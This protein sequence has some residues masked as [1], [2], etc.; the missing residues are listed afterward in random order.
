MMIIF[1][2]MRRMT[3]LHSITI[4]EKI[5]HIS[6]FALK[7]NILLH[8]IP[9]IFMIL[10]VVLPEVLDR[11]NSYRAAYANRGGHPI[12]TGQLYQQQPSRDPAYHSNR[13]SRRPT[14][15]QGT[16]PRDRYGVPMKCM[17][18]ES[19]YHFAQNCHDNGEE[20]TYLV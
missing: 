6:Q 3:I 2:A 18:C 5:H 4:D 8:R 16:N 11:G 7:Q 1:T 17:V 13:G 12:I 20:S 15:K 10:D 14:A 19:I 9:F